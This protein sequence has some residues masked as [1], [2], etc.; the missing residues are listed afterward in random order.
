MKTNSIMVNGTLIE[1]KTPYVVLERCN[2][3][4]TNNDGQNN[5]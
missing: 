3:T 4:E 5:R 2:Y 1:L